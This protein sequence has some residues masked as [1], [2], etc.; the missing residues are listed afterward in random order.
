MSDEKNQ[1]FLK[2]AH[3]RGMTNAQV[4]YVVE[5]ALNE[6]APDLLQGNAQLNSDECMAE[7]KT[8]WE[9]DA[10]LNQ[11]LKD[12]SKFFKSLPEEMVETI[13]KKFGND[14]DFIK[15]AALFGKE[16]AEDK[17][18]NPDEVLGGESISTL[19][20]SE[21]YRNPRHPDHDAVSKKVKLFYESKYGTEAV[22]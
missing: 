11:N 2:G 21:A 7:L 19:E 20:T 12:A 9:S 17:A 10:E 22:A 6:F 8:V 18:P 14:P 4:Q 5:H 3:A 13:D 16:M 15:V 1:G